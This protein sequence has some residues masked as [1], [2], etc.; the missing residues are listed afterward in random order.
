MDVIIE[1]VG[2]GPLDGKVMC[3]DSDDRVE[4]A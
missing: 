4:Q 1:F 3:S 2:G